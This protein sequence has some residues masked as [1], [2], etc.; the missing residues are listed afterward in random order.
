MEQKSIKNYNQ[1]MDPNDDTKQRAEKKT[2]VFQN[3]RWDSISLQIMDD[4]MA[5]FVSSVFPSLLFTLLTRLTLT[6]NYDVT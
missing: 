6:S 5:S 2:M 4:G 1:R 3:D